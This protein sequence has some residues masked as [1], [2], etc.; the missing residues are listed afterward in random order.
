MK[1]AVG[2]ENQKKS[3]CQ[4]ADSRSLRPTDGKKIPGT[5][6]KAS[7]ASLYTLAL[8]YY[9][10]HVM[11]TARTFHGWYRYTDTLAYFGDEHTAP[12]CIKNDNPR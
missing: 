10:T 11:H 9:Y 12:N 4:P 7:S 2:G 8:Y 3:P 5:N 6:S 1:K